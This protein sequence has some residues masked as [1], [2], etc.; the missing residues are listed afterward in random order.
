MN[1]CIKEMFLREY[2]TAE[3]L[4]GPLHD[5]ERMFYCLSD[6]Y[7]I[8][9]SEAEKTV[10]LTKRRSVR[11]IDT[12]LRY[13]RY[14]RLKQLADESG[15]PFVVCDE[16]REMIEIK[17]GAIVAADKNKLLA[18]KNASGIAVYSQLEANANRGAIDAMRILGIIL[19]EGIF[20][21]KNTAAGKALLQKTSRWNNI[22]GMLAS[23]KYG[24]DRRADY[25]RLY[26]VA[27]G[28]YST[29]VSAAAERYGMSG[30]VEKAEECALLDCAVGLGKLDSEIYVPTSARL[31]YGRIISLQDRRRILVS[32][33]REL[34]NDAD[35]LPLKLEFGDI[36]FDERA[37]DRMAVCRETER[38][39]ILQAVYNSDLRASKSY[40]EMCL[41]SDSEY[42]QDAYADA[43]AD[44]FGDSAVT[45]IE[46]SALCDEDITPTKNNI[47]VRSCD[48]DKNNVF[49]IFMRGDVKPNA[50]AVVK[51]F[52]TGDKRKNM[53][54]TVPSVGIDLGA[55]LPVCICDKNNARALKALCD[56]IDLANVGE[57]EKN[58]VI[59]GLLKSKAEYYGL[60]SVKANDAARKLLVSNDADDTARIIDK[61]VRDNRKK[62]KSITLT[63]A[64]VEAYCGE[65]AG[66]AGKYGFGGKV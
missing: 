44:M 17:G 5:G 8:P 35:D 64:M 61:A 27:G 3:A 59:D 60:K 18:P 15:S 16:E 19:C 58:A 1:N 14:L 66:A 4:L 33:N 25:A 63:E 52:L 7:M 41:C 40:R 51:M 21:D 26:T 24:F 53:R 29:L 12:V 56:V 34:I 11:E 30:A 22:G 23:L 13:Y 49:L 57:H 31:I 9:C 6:I 50:A 65:R 54:L 10:A 2:F 46:C 42:I 28:P 43:L 37:F 20:V 39:K 47:F 36:E 62:G 48:E 55:V 38:E 32:D 45:R